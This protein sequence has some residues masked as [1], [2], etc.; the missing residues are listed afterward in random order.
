MN[1]VKSV[2]LL[3]FIYI[4]TRHLD[5]L[6][7]GV[8]WLTVYNRNF[9]VVIICLLGSTSTI[10]EVFDMNHV[11]S[12]E[13]RF[14]Q[15]YTRAP[16]PGCRG[17]ERPTE[18]WKEVGH[19]REGGCLNWKEILEPFYSFFLCPSV[20]REQ[21][22]VV[23]F[24]THK[25]WDFDDLW[26]KEERERER[27]KGGG[28]GGLNMMQTIWRRERRLP[29]QPALFKL[30]RKWPYIQHASKLPFPHCLS[31]SLRLHQLAHTPN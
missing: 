23:F 10:Y 17:D 6:C 2:S 3:R 1:S 31:L 30:E 9:S 13:G 21:R 12:W 7:R 18:G 11:G 20:E 5:G 15:P 8:A 29:A 19:F 24:P 4:P 28:G 22:G 14:T 27:G 25:I 16:S 26:R